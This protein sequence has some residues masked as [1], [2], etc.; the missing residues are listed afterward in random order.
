[1]N[2]QTH[3]EVLRRQALLSH[4]PVKTLGEL[5]R[6]VA[7]YYPQRVAAHW[8]EENVS[9]TYGELDQMSSRLACGLRKMGVRKGSHVAIHLPNGLEFPVSWLAVAKLGAVMVPINTSYTDH[10]FRYTIADSDAQY[11][12]TNNAGYEKYRRSAE[13]LKLVSVD[14][15]IRIDDKRPLSSWRILADTSEPF[16]E[17]AGASSSDLANIQ[18]TSGTT[19]F[20]KGCMLSHEYWLMQSLNAAVLRSPARGAIENVLIWAPFFYMDPQWQ[21]LMT[22]QLGAT[23][24]IASQMSL[25]RFIEWIQRYDIHYC[26][27]PEPLLKRLPEQPRKVATPLKYVTIYGW[28]ES[29]RALF[30]ERFDVPC[31]EGYGMTETGTV[32]L[33]PTFDSEKTVQRTCGI[34]VPGKKVGIFDVN[35]GLVANGEVGELWVKGRGLSWGYYKRPESNESTYAHQWFRTG[36]LFTCDQDGYYYLVGRIKDMIKRAGENVAAN[37]V[38]AVLKEQDLVEE[39]AVVAAPDELR[40]EEVKAYLIVPD[41]TTIDDTL[42]GR[43]LDH[44]AVSL[45]PFK[46]PRYLEFV[47]DFPRTPSRKVAKKHLLGSAHG[48]MGACFDRETKR[49]IS[50]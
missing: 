24:H 48:A 5:V 28:I 50:A 40:R 34:P 11:L 8:F 6:R 21:F 31:R 35:G 26:V 7:L 27:F 37:E 43:V 18:Y 3:H 1:M 12:I 20:P 33:M 36:D 29:N 4:Y 2:S 32:L 25:T 22:L 17:E 14:R 23:A 41:G 10:E 30:Q 15:V 44:C 9:L 13:S 45:A 19:G 38:E 39:A 16:H 47:D 49:W 42:V 46:I